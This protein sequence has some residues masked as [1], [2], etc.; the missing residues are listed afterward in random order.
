MMRSADAFE[1]A[2]PEEDGVTVMLDLVVRNSGWDD[3]T[4]GKAPLA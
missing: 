2:F 4:L 3:E 1:L